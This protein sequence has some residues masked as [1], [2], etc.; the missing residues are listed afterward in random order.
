MQV[1]QAIAL[2]SEK[3]NNMTGIGID[4]RRFRIAIGH[5]RLGWGGSEKRVMW[6]I[7]ALKDDYDVTLI[8]SGNFDLEEPWF[9]ERKTGMTIIVRTEIDFV[10]F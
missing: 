2:R 10:P 1:F 9:E 7:E 8:T 5:P 4:E 3:K 6:G